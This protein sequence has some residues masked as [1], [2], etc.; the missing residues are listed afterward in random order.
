MQMDDKEIN[1]RRL[2]DRLKERRG[3][4]SRM[5]PH[6]RPGKIVEYGCGS[7]FVLEFVASKFPDSLIV[8]IDRSAERLA[9]VVA[10][11]LP[12]VLPVRTDI[13]SDIFPAGTFSTALFVAVLHE[14]FSVFGQGGVLDVLK[15]VGCALDGDGVVIIQ[16]FL[17]PPPRAVEV[18]FESDDAQARFFRF[19]AEFRQRKV[20]FERTGAGV[21]LDIADAVEFVSKYDSQTEED[22][23]HEMD[24]THFVCTEEGFRELA[25]ATGFE[26]DAVTR[27]P[28]SE[29][30]LREVGRL[31]GLDL[32]GDYGWIQ[33][34]L[35][36][37]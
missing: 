21:R 26:V 5:V 27:L 15:Q 10:G 29:K 34:V 22:W 1:H 37:A 24:E 31:I 19:A 30:R 9:E 28:T 13:T 20:V 32:L 7:G 6:I 35:K 17:R 4:L 2:D 36:K 23:E 12:N 3:W 14:V 18:S 16:D 33:I 11:G 8:G 25:G